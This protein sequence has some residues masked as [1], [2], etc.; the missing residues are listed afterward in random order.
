MNCPGSKPFE[1]D[2]S[3]HPGALAVHDGMLG[4]HGAFAPR[5]GERMLILSTGR[6]I[7]VPRT[8]TELGCDPSTCPDS[9]F[10]P[11][12]GMP[13]LPPPINVRRVSDDG[14]TCAE[15]PGLVGMGDCSNTLAEEWALGAYAYDYAELRLKSRVPDNTDGFAY[16]F[17]F[18]SAEYPLYAELG[19]PWNDMYIAWLES[20]AWT[21]N[22]SFDQHGH[23]ISIN[24]VFLDYL[25]ADSPRCDVYPCVAPELDGS[26]WTATRAPAGWRRSPPWC[27]ARTSRWCSR[28]STWPMPIWTRSSCWTTCT[29]IARIY[30]R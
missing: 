23:P 20:E 14:Q 16:Q 30:R 6:A 24:G 3:G 1:V 8:H 10:E 2:F 21:G 29:G 25:D 15:D 13:L 27:P 18:F 26:R 28:S 12:V 4:T 9:A 11:E 7:D 5:E 22:I 17:A 19:S